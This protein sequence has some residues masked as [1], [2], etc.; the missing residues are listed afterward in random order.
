[1]LL[2]IS[3][4]AKQQGAPSQPTIWRMTKNKRIP[5]FLV[6]A[7]GGWRVDTASP[8]WGAYVQG[9]PKRALPQTLGGTR[10]KRPREK[11]RQQA[12]GK[13]RAAAGIMTM[14]RR[15]EKKKELAVQ[16]NSR[17]PFT[18]FCV[19]S[20]NRLSPLQYSIF[21]KHGSIIRIRREYSAFPSSPSIFCRIFSIKLSFPFIVKY[22]VLRGF[23]S[24]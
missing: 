14:K 10:S 1:M 5:G 8:E 24:F 9:V 12:R 22:N 4:A 23:F 21:A 6:Q 19:L 17:C 11:R 20:V 16:N 18:F 13:S 2:T 7:D 15:K 3:E